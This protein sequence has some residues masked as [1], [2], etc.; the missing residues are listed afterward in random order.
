MANREEM[1]ISMILPLVMTYGLRSGELFVFFVPITKSA[2]WWI[3]HSYVSCPEGRQGLVS[4]S[5]SVSHHPTKK[6]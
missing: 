2:Q 3:V 6:I 4:M 5:R 1:S